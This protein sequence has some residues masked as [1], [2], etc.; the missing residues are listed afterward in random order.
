MHCVIYYL[1]I[2]V[3]LSLCCSSV[4]AADIGPRIDS[5]LSDEWIG[6]LPEW[7][8]VTRDFGAKGMN[9]SLSISLPLLLSFPSPPLTISP[10][11]ILSLLN[12]Y[13]FPQ[14]MASQTTQ[15]HCRRQSTMPP[16]TSSCTSLLAHMSS[17]KCST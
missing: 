15:W 7:R 9:P 14:E 6:P 16:I 4:H 13:L 1:F 10:S 5:S 2:A 11:C 17:P 3:L 12:S 8:W